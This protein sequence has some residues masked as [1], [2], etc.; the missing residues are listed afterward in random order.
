MWLTRE[1]WQSL[2]PADPLKGN[3]LDV[4]GNIADVNNRCI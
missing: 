3:E 1:E 2:V 4:G